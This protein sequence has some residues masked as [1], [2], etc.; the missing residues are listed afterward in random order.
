MKELKNMLEILSISLT[1]DTSGDIWIAFNYIYM[2]LYI[3]FTN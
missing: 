3:I 2:C 1:P